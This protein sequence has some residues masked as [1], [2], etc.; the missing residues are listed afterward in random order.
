MP[1]MEGQELA[2]RLREARPT[3]PVIFMSGYAGDVLTQ[4]G[5]L[6]AG[7]DFVP[8]PFQLST[9][10]ERVQGALQGAHR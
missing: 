4:D 3:L 6:P 10:A 1:K 5:T 7:T 9:L 8:K 2:M